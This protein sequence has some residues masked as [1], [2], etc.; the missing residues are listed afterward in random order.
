MDEQRLLQR[1]A[2]DSK[3]M[4]GKAVIKGTRLTIQYVLGLMAAG[5]T[6]EDIL[7]EYEGLT[8]EDV[9][10]CLLFAKEALDRTSFV[11]L[12]PNPV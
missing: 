4:T 2:L 12:M 7:R 8:T 1:V 3:V 11:P 10:A 6:V 9:Q 5:A